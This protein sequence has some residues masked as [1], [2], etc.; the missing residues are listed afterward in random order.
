MAEVHLNYYRGM[1]KIVFGEEQAK[2]IFDMM[3][4][5]EQLGYVVQAV[6]A[7][8]ADTEFKPELTEEEVQEKKTNLDSADMTS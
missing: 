6:S 4:T 7:I 5:D 2:D 8:L 3:L 1:L